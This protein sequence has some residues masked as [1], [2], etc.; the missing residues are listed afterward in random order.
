MQMLINANYVGGSHHNCAHVLSHL[1]VFQLP[2]TR[3]YSQ[4]LLLMLLYRH[5]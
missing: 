5:K 3:I 1:I 4:L 2:R